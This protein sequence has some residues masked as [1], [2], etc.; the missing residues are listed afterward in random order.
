MIAHFFC[1]ANAI[2]CKKMHCMSVKYEEKLKRYAK[3]EKKTASVK[4]RICKS[5]IDKIRGMVYHI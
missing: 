3:C 1:P 4:K 5:D 2:L